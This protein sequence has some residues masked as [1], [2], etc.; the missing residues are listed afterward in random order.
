MGEKESER[1]KGGGKDREEYRRRQSRETSRGIN[2]NVTG[3]D[4]ASNVNDVT[5]L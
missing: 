5:M 4:G 3:I 2:D 1:E